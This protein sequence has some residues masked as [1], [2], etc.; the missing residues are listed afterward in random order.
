MIG[1]VA[2]TLAM[3]YEVR[4]CCIPRNL[5]GWLDC[6]RPDGA[7]YMTLGYIQSSSPYAG[8]LAE[9]TQPTCHSIV[10]EFEEYGETGCPPVVAIKSNEIPLATFKMLKG[11]IPCVSLG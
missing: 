5:L 8:R 9:S 7:R 3:R 2:I 4:C 11:F 6:D 1:L 10:I